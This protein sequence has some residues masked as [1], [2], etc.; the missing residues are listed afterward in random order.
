MARN[1]AAAAACCSAAVLLLVVS[2]YAASDTKGP[3][4]AVKAPDLA[5]G[6]EETGTL[7]PVHRDTERELEKKDIKAGTRGTSAGD[8][9]SLATAGEQGQ[10]DGSD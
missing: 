8:V 2:V 5:A 10:G 1:A 7:L 4:T 6:V 9:A 3:R